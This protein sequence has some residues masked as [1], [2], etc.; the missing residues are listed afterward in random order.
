MIWRRRG[1]EPANL[2]M[3]WAANNRAKAIECGVL[4]SVPVNDK[5]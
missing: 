1:F 2:T 4:R 5:G 3:Q